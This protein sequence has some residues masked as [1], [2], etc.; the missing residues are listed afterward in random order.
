MKSFRLPIVARFTEDVMRTWERILRESDRQ[1]LKRGQDIHL[2]SAV[3]VL[4]APD[5]G[6]WKL[7]VDNSGTVSSSAYTAL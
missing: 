3:V 5:G 7:E 4:T 6:K 2:G 1:N